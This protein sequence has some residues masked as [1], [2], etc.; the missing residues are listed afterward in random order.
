MD[1]I[2][3]CPTVPVAVIK[4]VLKKYLEKGIHELPINSVKSLKLSNVIF[5]GNKRGGNKNNSSSDLNALDTVIINGYAENVPKMRS[6]K[7][8][9]ASPQRERFNFRF[10]LK[11][12]VSF[13]LL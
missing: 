11:F 1:A 8:N 4:I 3:T 6:N 2:K 13:N 5:L 9:A 12:N 10:F 7:N